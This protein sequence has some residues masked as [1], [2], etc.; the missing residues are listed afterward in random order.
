M[1]LL[2]TPAAD[3][4]LHLPEVENDDSTTRGVVQHADFFYSR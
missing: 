3:R 4:P 2:R 1:L